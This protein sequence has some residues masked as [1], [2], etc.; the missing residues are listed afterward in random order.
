MPKI[1]DHQNIREKIARKAIPLFREEGYRALSFRTIASRLELS[2]SGLYHYFKNKKELFEFCGAIILSGDLSVL[3]ISDDPVE[4]LLL[5]TQ[6]WSVFFREELRL[7]IDFNQYITS[8]G[9][10]L[11]RMKPIFENVQ[12]SIEQLIGVDKSYIVLTMILG[13]LLMRSL[14]KDEQSWS[15]FE[16]SLRIVVAR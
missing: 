10:R 8:E 14:A 16:K 15:L 3:S 12:H 4:P 7:L 6:K 1:V 2:K 13:E 9:D 11:D 5:L